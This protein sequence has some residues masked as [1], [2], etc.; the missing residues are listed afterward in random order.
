MKKIEKIQ[1]T[2]K[3]QNRFSIQEVK[4][5]KRL[6]KCYTGWQN[7]GVFMRIYNRIHKKADK[8]WYFRRDLSFISKS[9]QTRKNT[10]NSDKLSLSIDNCL[11]LTLIRLLVGLIETDLSHEYH[12]CSKNFHLSFIGQKRKVYYGI[13]QNVLRDIKMLL[14][15]LIA[16]KAY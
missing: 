15:L 2:N 8:L 11:L 6:V 3:G 9:Y 10:E 4:N 5:S 14:V 16:R 12:F 13:I 7:H 1:N